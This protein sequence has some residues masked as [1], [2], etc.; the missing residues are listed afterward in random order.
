MKVK[1]NSAMLV[2]FP[3]DDTESLVSVGAKIRCTD[4]PSDAEVESEVDYDSS[5]DEP[6]ETIFGPTNKK[7]KIE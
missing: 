6:L 4:P 2:Y 1:D 7:R 3:E 5:E